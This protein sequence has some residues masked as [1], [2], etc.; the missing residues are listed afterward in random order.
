M[1]RFFLFASAAMLL[2]IIA[3]G[4]RAGILSGPVTNPANGHDYYLLTPD[5]WSASEFDAERLGGTL[6][7]IQNAAEQEW[8]FS[9]FGDFR[10]TNRSLWIGRRRS[11]PGGPFASVTDAKMVY[12]NW[13]AGQPDN[14]GGSENFIQILTTG[15]WN[16]NTDTANPVCGIVEVPGKSAETAPH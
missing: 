6:A 4:V 12:F 7:V 5:T 16:D 11:W 2:I 1:K 13:D 15:K 3:N 14:A 9:K 8:V 10:G